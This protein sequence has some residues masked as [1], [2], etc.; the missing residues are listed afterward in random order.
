VALQTVLASHKTLCCD[1]NDSNED[2][3]SYKNPVLEQFHPQHILQQ[4]T[5][6]RALLGFTFS[7]GSSLQ[8]T[9]FPRP[10]TH[11]R[12]VRN[13]TICK[14]VEKDRNLICTVLKFGGG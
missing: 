10:V 5:C 2:I 6:G 9:P 13:E 14:N 1:R 8:A 11:E 4:S 12:L 7:R 3:S